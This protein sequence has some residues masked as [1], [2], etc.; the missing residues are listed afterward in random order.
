MIIIIIIPSLFKPSAVFI[1]LMLEAGAE[2]MTETNNSNQTINRFKNP[3][4]AGG[5]PAGY[6]Q[7]ESRI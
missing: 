1:A 5:K 7:A 3:Q 2:Q 4:L 6:L